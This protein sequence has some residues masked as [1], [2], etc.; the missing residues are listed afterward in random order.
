MK[1]EIRPRKAYLRLAWLAVGALFLLSPWAAASSV[2]FSYDP[3]GR[4]NTAAYDNGLCIVYSYDANGN[5]TAVSSSAGPQSTD[6]GTATWGCFP[7]TP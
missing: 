2:Q 1:P 3:V 6:W 5:R 7:W 4:L